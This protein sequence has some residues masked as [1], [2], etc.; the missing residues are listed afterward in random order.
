MA[1]AALDTTVLYAAADANDERHEDALPILRGIDAGSLP[2]GDVIEFVLGE[3]LN[4]VVR[5][6]S[7]GSAVDY[8]DRIEA[9]GRFDISRLTT[10]AFA[11]GKAIFRQRSQ[12]SLVDGLIVGHMR[13]RGIRYLYSFD[14]GFDGIDDVTRLTRPENPFQPE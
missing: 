2:E 8:L 7:H 3:T 11:T 14:S 9:N 4:G 10:D 12:L 1:V 13:D 5:N 6:L